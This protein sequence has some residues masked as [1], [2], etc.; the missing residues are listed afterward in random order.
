MHQLKRVMNEHP[1][2]FLERD[3]DNKIHSAGALQ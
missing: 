1:A 3:D 2:F